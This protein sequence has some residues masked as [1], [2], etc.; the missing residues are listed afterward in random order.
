MWN[1]LQNRQPNDLYATRPHDVKLLYKYEPSIVEGKIWECACGHGHIVRTLQE[2]GATDVYASDLIDYGFGYD[3]YDFLSDD[4]TYN[5]EFDTI[6]TNPPY[7][8]TTEFMRRAIDKVKPG[9]RVI[10]LLPTTTLAGVNRY[11]KIFKTDPP[12]YI[13]T[14]SRNTYALLVAEGDKI[15]APKLS[16][17]WFIWEKG[18]KGETIVRWLYEDE[19]PD[20][21]VSEIVRQYRAK[22]RGE[23]PKQPVLKSENPGVRKRGSTW[24]SR[25]KVNGKYIH[26]GRYATKEEA[27]MAR[28]QAEIKYRGGNDNE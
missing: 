9:G 1:Q 2:L 6:L 12:K 27:I 17:S 5:N 3:I 26:L 10:M 4:D 24:E 28:K 8:F 15:G 18:Y 19:D 11:N 22:R 13:Y 25:I 23:S 7:K 14:F 16:H 21:R 20:S